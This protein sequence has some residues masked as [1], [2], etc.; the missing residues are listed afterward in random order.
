MHSLLPLPDFEAAERTADRLSQ[1]GNICSDGRPTLRLDCRT[2]LNWRLT[3]VEF[4]LYSC[5]YM[6]AAF[7]GIRRVSDLKRP[8]SVSGDMT[9]YVYAME[10]DF[11]QIR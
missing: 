5:S 7:F 8:M 11:R 3:S 9:S 1:I 10:T 4:D 2:F 6:D